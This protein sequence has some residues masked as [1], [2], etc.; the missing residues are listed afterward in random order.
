[1]SW[2]L[3][4]PPVNG[5]DLGASGCGWCVLPGVIPRGILLSHH[6]LSPHPCRG[7][8]KCQVWVAYRLHQF[9]GRQLE[10]CRPTMGLTIPS[11]FQMFAA[12]SAGWGALQPS[13]QDLPLVHCPAR[14]PRA[15]GRAGE[16]DRDSRSAQ[17]LRRSAFL[18]LL[19]LP[20]KG[21]CFLLGIGLTE[22]LAPRQ[23]YK[24]FRITV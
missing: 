11:R 20:L 10:K 17:H 6:P 15:G 23:L 8:R 13:P 2:L 24:V 12:T 22:M 16:G 9:T 18:S 3:P 5:V 7:L 14:V 1:M 4:G 19:P 21:G